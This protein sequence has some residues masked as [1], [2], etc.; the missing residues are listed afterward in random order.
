[1]DDYWIGINEAAK[2]LGVNKDIIRNWIKKIDIP[3]CKM[4]KL[5]KSKKS[6]IDKWGVVNFVLIMQ[7]N[8][9]FC[10]IFQWAYAL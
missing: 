6:A 8:N 1:M 5:W 9:F 7:L 2:Y 4:G 10:L 3:A